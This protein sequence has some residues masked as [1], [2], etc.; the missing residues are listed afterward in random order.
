MMLGGLVAGTP[1]SGAEN[2]I[3]TCRGGSGGGGAG[4]GPNAGG[5]VPGNNGTDGLGGGGGAGY[6]NGAPASSGG[7][8]GSGRVVVRGPSA[9]TFSVSPG[10]NTT[11]TA[12]NGDK[13]AIFTVSGTLTTTG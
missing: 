2:P 5:S 12:P 3:P 1:V 11:T 4:G 7:N 10:T 6:Y 8:G 9:F 13:V